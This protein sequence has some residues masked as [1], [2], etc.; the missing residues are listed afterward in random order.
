M[1]IKI[2]SQGSLNDTKVVNAETGE[3]LEMV[4][5]ITWMQTTDSAHPTCWIELVGVNLEVE[6]DAKVVKK[7]V[8]DTKNYQ[9]ASSDKDFEE[10]VRL[11]TTTKKKKR[12]AS[13]VPKKPAP[14]KV[15][16][17]AKKVAQ[18]SKKKV[19]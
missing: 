7:E 11:A 13:S 18:K 6:V 12:K 17:K 5:K 14:K 10:S 8:V 4:Q 19:K 1:K 9:F 3:P 16:A 15:A 2:V